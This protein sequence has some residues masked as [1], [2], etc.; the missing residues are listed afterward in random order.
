MPDNNEVYETEEL[1]VAAYFLMMNVK[2]LKNE[3]NHN[4]VR[5]T[6]EDDGEKCKKLVVDFLNSDFKIYDGIVR[7]LKK[8]FRKK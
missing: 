3:Y 2:M 4:K 1:N 8:T 5:F 6:F 7:D